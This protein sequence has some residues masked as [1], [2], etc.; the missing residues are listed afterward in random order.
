MHREIVH[1]GT[2][3]GFV[4]A[5]VALT[6]TSAVAQNMLADAA[7]L[8][9]RGE[10]QAAFD[11]LGK[12][13][14]QSAGDLA[15]DMA[16]GDAA[17]AAG[18]YSRSILAFERA[19]LSHPGHAGAQAALA[20]SLQAVGDAAGAQALIPSPLTPFINPLDA[21]HQNQQFNTVEQPTHSGLTTIKGHVEVGFGHDSN[22]NAGP[23]DANLS[24]V[25]PGG[26]GTWHLAPGGSARAS[27][28][29]GAGA[30]VSGRLM[31]VPTWS[32]YG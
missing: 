3:L 8:R 30:A 24:G 28:M 20:K 32:L 10:H 15:Y 2:Q 16:L 29:W 4:M 14:G 25:L 5:A 6:S 17:Y 1:F 18:H 13:E 19:Y 9:E 12:Q 11:L 7:A 22:A 31:L 26:G 27:D 23:A 21:W